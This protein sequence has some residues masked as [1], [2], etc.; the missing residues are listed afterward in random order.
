MKK[1]SFWV[2]LI[3]AIALLSG[4]AL[5]WQHHNTNADKLIANV[6]LDGE[7]VRSIDLNRLTEPETFT[8]SGPAGE[9][10]ITA[11]PGRI[12]VSHADC[13]D[14]VCVNMGWRSD[15]KMPIVCLP[16][17]LVIEIEDSA[18]DTETPI[19]GVVG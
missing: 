12:C 3:A 16:N 4:A 2:I 6:Y 9:N 15:G 7:C 14:Q 19:D 10:T 5:L 1:T 18:Q 8:V 17:R 11:E 13:P